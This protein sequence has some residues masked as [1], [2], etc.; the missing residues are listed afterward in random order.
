MIP[1][2]KIRFEV[3][4]H[5]EDTPVRGNAIDSGDDAQDKACE[6]SI[7]KRLDN[8]DIW[9]WCCVEVKGTIAGLSTSN[10]LGGCSYANESDFRKGGYFKDMCTTVQADLTARWEEL[11]RELGN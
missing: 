1:L 5:W 2:N 11:K 4:P 8:G 7:L 6:D 9:G 10:Y 3:I